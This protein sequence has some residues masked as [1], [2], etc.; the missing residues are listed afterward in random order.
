MRRGC[1]HGNECN[2]FLMTGVFCRRRRLL[3]L[4]RDGEAANAAR[5]QFCMGDA[6]RRQ[7]S[8]SK[9]GSN[10]LWMVGKEVGKELAVWT[11]QV[12][13]YGQYMCSVARCAECTIQ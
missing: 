8:Y 1:L 10:W 9:L 7:L 12:A 2:D 4:P 6:W 13:Q 5:Q 3:L 11:V